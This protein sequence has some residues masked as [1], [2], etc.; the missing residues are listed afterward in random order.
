MMLARRQ[1]PPNFPRYTIFGYNPSTLG[2]NPWKGPLCKN[3]YEQSPLS[4]SIYFLRIFQ[5]PVRPYAA[6]RTLTARQPVVQDAIHGL[7]SSHPAL[8]VYMNDEPARR[9]KEVCRPHISPVSPS[10]FAN[11]RVGSH[12]ASAGPQTPFITFPFLSLTY[13]VFLSMCSIRSPWNS[14]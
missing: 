2:N 10:R 14:V 13:L 7:R 4:R 8:L 11:D 9:S 6:R 5:N 12:G 3:I 1:L